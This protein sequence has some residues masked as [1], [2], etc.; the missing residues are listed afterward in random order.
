[1]ASLE[2]SNSKDWRYIAKSLAIISVV[3]FL[4]TGV[5]LITI[6]LLSRSHNNMTVFNQDHL[7]S[8]YSENK[9]L[10]ASLSYVK[11]VL[12]KFVSVMRNDKYNLNLV[13]FGQDTIDGL[14]RTYYLTDYKENLEKEIK[15]L[16]NQLKK[17]KNGK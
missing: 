11:S 12:E 13:E 10:R 2:S 9:D 14:D 7:D 4:L 8:V 5:L 15:K 1:M 3:I 6:G 17:V 16:K